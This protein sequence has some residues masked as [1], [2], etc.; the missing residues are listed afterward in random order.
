MLDGLG[1]GVG[2]H[3]SQLVHLMAP[4]LVADMVFDEL[5]FRLRTECIIA[6]AGHVA[7]KLKNDQVRNREFECAVQCDRL[8]LNISLRSTSAAAVGYH[9]PPD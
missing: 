9:M 1:V 5:E 2:G 4:N 8:C 6:A 7:L 3:A